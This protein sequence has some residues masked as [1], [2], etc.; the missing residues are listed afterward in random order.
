VLYT[1]RFL[2]ILSRSSEDG[3]H[4]CAVG[5]S[6]QWLTN[7]DQMSYS[8]CQIG[9]SVSCLVSVMTGFTPAETVG[10]IGFR[11]CANSSPATTPPARVM[12]NLSVLDLLNGNAPLS[13]PAAPSG[14]WRSHP[15]RCICPS[16][17]TPIHTGARPHLRAHTP[18]S[19]HQAEGLLHV[20]GIHDGRILH[21]VEVES[22]AHELVAA[23]LV[24]RLRSQARDACHW[25]HGGPRSKQAQPHM[26][27]AGEMQ[28][29]ILVELTQNF[30]E[31]LHCWCFYIKKQSSAKF[32]GENL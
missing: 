9:P 2:S 25:A 24:V 28:P 13:A 16:H 15:G 17:T 10:A 11:K 8:A 26:Q 31:K 4:A 7:R 30:L 18:D 12:C 32:H 5:R 29:I 27:P 14:D 20:D 21:Y 6:C 23:R 22:L 3:P 19:P 1:L